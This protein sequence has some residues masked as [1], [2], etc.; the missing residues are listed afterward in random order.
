MIAFLLQMSENTSSEEDFALANA[1]K[2]GIEFQGLDLFKEQTMP[3]CHTIRRS[4][5]Q[6]S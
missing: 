1:V 3:R 5:R 2:I 6:I 4:H